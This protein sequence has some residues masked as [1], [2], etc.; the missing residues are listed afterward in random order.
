MQVDFLL[1]TSVVV[2]ILRRHQAAV[3]WLRQN[4]ELTLGLPGFV[5]F[6]ILQGARNKTEMIQLQKELQS[7]PVFWPAEED[8]NQALATYAALSLSHG[9]EI[10]DALI[11]CTAI[12]TGL[13]LL[14]L[15][16]KHFDVIPGLTCSVPY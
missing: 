7:F 8:C 4:S 14:T 6:E 11:G 12:G 13:P 15:D 9:L 10:M 5:A 1:D 2:D 3:S 16:T